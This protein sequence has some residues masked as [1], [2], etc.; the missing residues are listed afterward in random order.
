MKVNKLKFINQSIGTSSLK[1]VNLDH[2][3]IK[4]LKEV[5]SPASSV[6]RAL[7]S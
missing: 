2:K 5:V 3:R 4:N 1:K 7:G 6:G